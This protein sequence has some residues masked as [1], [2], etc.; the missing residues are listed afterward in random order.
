MAPGMKVRGVGGGFEERMA[1]LCDGR[2]RPR[3]RADRVE[4]RSCAEE[5]GP[6]GE[7]MRR[8]T[9]RVAFLRSRAVCSFQGFLSLLV[10][11]KLPHI[12]SLG[13]GC[14]N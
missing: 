13:R 2:P 6:V 9:R 11:R 5:L 8:S 10:R 1:D 7:E 3:G 4:G 12:R 14:L